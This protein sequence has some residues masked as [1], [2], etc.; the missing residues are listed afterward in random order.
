MELSITIKLMIFVALLSYYL[1]FVIRLL[2][3]GKKKVLITAIKLSLQMVLV[4]LT[5]PYFLFVMRRSDIFK[6]LIR[7]AIDKALKEENI[8][9]EFDEDVYNTIL[10]NLSSP[11]MFVRFLSE[12]VIDYFRNWDN[13][14]DR[15]VNTAPSKESVKFSFASTLIGQI[16]KTINKNRIFHLRMP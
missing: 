2:R 4:P 12:L 9:Q 5:F 6:D 13:N 3:C 7:V 8:F 16:S 1:G 14:V 10:R 15:L 11:K